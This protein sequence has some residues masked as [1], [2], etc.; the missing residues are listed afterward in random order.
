MASGQTAN[1]GLNQWAAEDKVSREEF[2]Q[3]N[4]K[5]EAA[6][7]NVTETGPKIITG[8]YIGTGTQDI[9]HYSIGAQP[10]FL[11]LLTTNG[12]GA[13]LSMVMVMPSHYL[14]LQK[15]GSNQF[16]TND[17][18][19]FEEDGFTVNHQKYSVGM[20]LNQGITCYC[21]FC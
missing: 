6:I 13:G 17:Y 16:M 1:F 4:L 12:D 9:I 2:N 8:S 10:K 21:A 20:G 18:V 15:N 5:I 7:F 3:D 19:T 11:I 14:R